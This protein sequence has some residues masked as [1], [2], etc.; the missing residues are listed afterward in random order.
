MLDTAE[1][2]ASSFAAATAADAGTFTP[3]TLP[4]AAVENEIAVSPTEVALAVRHGSDTPMSLVY[5]AAV[6]ISESAS[7]GDV[8]MHLALLGLHGL[9]SMSL[10]RFTFC[11]LR[12]DYKPYLSRRRDA[13][14]DALIGTP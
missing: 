11:S 10:R 13:C 7:F 2:I 9:I 14:L 8:R 5:E 1:E 6:Q 4:V 12:C 3:A